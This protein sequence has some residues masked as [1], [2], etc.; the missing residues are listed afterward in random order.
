MLLQWDFSSTS[1]TMKVEMTKVP[2]DKYPWKLTWPDK[3][4][5]ACDGVSESQSIQLSIRYTAVHE[6]SR[7]WRPEG[8]PFVLKPSSRDVEQDKGKASSSF[9]T[10]DPQQTLSKQMSVWW[11]PWTCQSVSRLEQQT[12]ACLLHYSFPP[13][14]KW[15]K[16]QRQKKTMT[17][18]G[19][20]EIHRKQE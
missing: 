1:Q 13:Y 8:R 3:Q 4:H 15:H 14:D 17:I 19:R 5:A 18:S 9:Y 6:P 12:Y 20:N 16:T 10:E 2:S 11:E 7:W